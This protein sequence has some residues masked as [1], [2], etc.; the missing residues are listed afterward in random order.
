[1]N[2]FNEVQKAVAE[3]R[4]ESDTTIKKLNQEFSN[5]WDLNKPTLDTQRKLK[6]LHMDYVK[7]DKELF[8][9]RIQESIKILRGL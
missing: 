2:T 8:I 5:L 1:M 4:I 6:K 9:E 7:R 3:D